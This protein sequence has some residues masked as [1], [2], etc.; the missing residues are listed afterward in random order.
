MMDDEL[1]L[2]GWDTL[3]FGIGVTELTVSK[4]VEEYLHYHGFNKSLFAL[5]AELK[6]R[7]YNRLQPATA[8]ACLAAFDEGNEQGFFNLWNRIV[9]GDLE[10]LHTL[11]VKLRIHFIIFSLRWKLKANQ[12]DT[13]LENKPNFNSLKEF[14]D[15]HPPRYRKQNDSNTL[16]YYALVY[17]E[18]PHLHP[19]YKHLFESTWV[20]T[21]RKETDSVINHYLTSNARKPILYDLVSAQ[22]APPERTIS[23]NSENQNI[24]STKMVRDLLQI[25]D[26]ILLQAQV[27]CEKNQQHIPNHGQD[28]ESDVK[29]K[30][31]DWLSKGKQRLE[32]FQNRA[33][34]L[35]H[36][37][38]YYP[39]G[40]S[41]ASV[42]SRQSLF[43]RYGPR[44]PRTQSRASTAGATMNK[45]RGVRQC[46]LPAVKDA[47]KDTLGPLPKTDFL[48]ISEIL[49][50]EQDNMHD[51]SPMF[52]SLLR[53]C[54]S[55]YEPLPSR[56]TF[57]HALCCF[58]I[59]NFDSTV[60][61]YESKL[62]IKLLSLDA[63]VA[64]VAVMACEEKGRT[65]LEKQ[66]EAVVTGL[67][68]HLDTKGNTE[69]QAIVALQRLSLR[70]PL[71]LKMIEKG[72]IEW[73]LNE[74][75]EDKD[76]RKN[77]SDIALEFGSALLMNLA[78]RTIGK[79]E[80][81]NEKSLKV[82]VS[83]LDFH[84]PQ[85]RT[86]ANGT[87]YSLFSLPSTHEIS[88]NLGIE[89]ILRRIIQ[90]EDEIHIKQLEYLLD[91]LE[92]GPK[93]ECEQSEADDLD[94]EC[95]LDEEELSA[96]AIPDAPY[97]GNELL[98]QELGPSAG[99]FENSECGKRFKEFINTKTVPEPPSALRTPIMSTRRTP[100][101]NH[102]RKKPSQAPPSQDQQFRSHPRSDIKGISQIPSPN[103]STGI[104]KYNNIDH[105]ESKE[106]RQPSKGSSTTAAS[107]VKST[108][109]MNQQNSEQAH[110]AIRGSSAEDSRTAARI[111]KEGQRQ[112][113]G[114]NL[115]KRK[116]K[117]SSRTRASQVSQDLK[118][119]QQRSR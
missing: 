73:I 32:G 34:S 20:H 94:D 31:P 38:N 11:E 67:M 59:F 96:W 61:E 25:F 79:K 116:E 78:L 57:L 21:L 37:S 36:E 56:R 65:Y 63:A 88:K 5:K 48:R 86:Q 29:K 42:V 101:Y 111:K 109:P 89:D 117:L 41:R 51:L 52:V 93:E 43:S 24:E 62:T 68:Q 95:F 115:L 19:D 16:S 84:L 55:A 72:L 14:L 85:V 27:W 108:G 76:Q 99:L 113:T 106:K 104:E 83:L 110:H 9:P 77:L 118:R 2:P 119:R 54:S 46:I 80:M 103:T 1:P 66:S 47:V 60:E 28:R 87:L 64:L 90:T 97:E 15:A 114:N 82:L 71:Q 22:Y 70:R 13:V 44:P 81:A 17:I 8:E 69:L 105:M 107:T 50:K 92:K 23:R 53:H 12:T 6:S 102:Q 3:D 7:K 45:N 4:A 100:S 75:G 49:A 35:I 98:P 10:Q 112:T 40:I 30:I 26:Q 58:D 39:R 74:F 33:R 18:L 91:L